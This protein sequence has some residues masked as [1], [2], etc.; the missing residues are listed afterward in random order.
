MDH[1]R[2]SP[3]A[4]SPRKKTRH[5]RYRRSTEDLGFS[6]WRNSDFTKQYLEQAHCKVQPMKAK[7]WAF[8]LEIVTRR[9]TNN[10]VKLCATPS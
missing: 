10:K 3:K 7:H 4:T 5:K 6:P 8:I 9:S 1:K 2:D